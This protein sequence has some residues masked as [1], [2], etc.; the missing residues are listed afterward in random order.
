MRILG[1]AV[2]L[3]LGAVSS[4]AAQA[5]LGT[6]NPPGPVFITRPQPHGPFEVVPEG[7]P[8]SRET[9]PFTDEPHRFNNPYPTLPNS[10]LGYALRYVQVPARTAVLP[11]YVPA[12][13]SFSGSYQSGV[14]EIPGYV[15]VETTT[16]Y[17]S[18]AH[19]DLQ[20]VTI[21][22]YQYVMLPATFQRK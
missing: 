5:G 18:P 15:V 14:V 8:G 17:F 12:P 13:G 4:A 22:V 6:V 7:T 19:W 21:G 16:G 20:E 2:A 10:G 11:V 3:V 9:I 1:I